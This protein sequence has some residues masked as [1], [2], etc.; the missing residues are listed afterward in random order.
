MHS[1]EKAWL[2]CARCQASQL[3][4]EILG[5]GGWT[6][7]AP[8][9]CTRRG[10]MSAGRRTGKPPNSEAARGK[11]WGWHEAEG[12]VIA[13]S[14]KIVPK[15]TF[16]MKSS[17]FKKKNRVKPFKPGK[18]PLACYCPRKENTEKQ[19]KC[20]GQKPKPEFL[21]GFTLGNAMLWWETIPK[22]AGR[23]HGEQVPL[24]PLRH[25]TDEVSKIHGN[26]AGASSHLARCSS[27]LCQI[28]LYLYIF[29]AYKWRANSP[30][31]HLP[32]CTEIP[33]F[34]LIRVR[35]KNISG[36][37]LLSCTLPLHRQNEFCWRTEST[38]CNGAKSQ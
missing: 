30:R 28:L 8:A 19:G 14:E 37:V 7:P 32:F 27:H 12:M 13:G 24:A 5:V 15:V 18:K 22:P 6:S 3:R 26:G 11:G 31:R 25:G 1:K 34:F 23:P 9:L 35:E 36:C 29:G 2:P 20:C 4:M 17:D 21:C 10:A 33:F 38:M 16:Q